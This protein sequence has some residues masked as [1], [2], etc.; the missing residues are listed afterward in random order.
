[1]IKVNSVIDE[2][3]LPYS[4]PLFFSVIQEKTY[5][6]ERQLRENIIIMFNKII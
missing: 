5:L 3:N 2:F 4:H 1:M 6:N